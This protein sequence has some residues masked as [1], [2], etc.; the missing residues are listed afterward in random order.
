MPSLGKSPVHHAVRGGPRYRQQMFVIELTYTAPL[1][2]IDAAMRRHMQFVRTH[3][4]SG[5][6]IVSGR[7]IPRVGG[8]FLATGGNRDDV[9]AIARQ[10]P[11]VSEGLA[12]VRVI[13]FRVS[14]RSH[15]ARVEDLQ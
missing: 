7:K 11:F 3:Y 13:E 4:A 10:D 12:E 15:S 14:Q 8:I 6:F 2:R 5:R 1:P 9:E